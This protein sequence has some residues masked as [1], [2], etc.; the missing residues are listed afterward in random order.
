MPEPITPAHR[1]HVQ[2]HVKDWC[3]EGKG[4]VNHQ[5]S[6]ALAIWINGGQGQQVRKM[7]AAAT[8]THLNDWEL[9]IVPTPRSWTDAR[10]TNKQVAAGVEEL[11]QRR[12][13]N[14]REN[15]PARPWRQAKRANQA[16]KETMT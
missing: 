7:L 15:R 8:G 5:V 3:P 11:R 2:I 1:F 4:L 13:E 10:M 6:E 9:Q 14:L 16:K 12:E